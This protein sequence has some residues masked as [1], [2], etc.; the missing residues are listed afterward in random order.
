MIA[1]N[2]RFL[3]KIHLEV[4]RGHQRSE[5]GKKAQIFYLPKKK[6]RS[7][8]SQAKS[9]KDICYRCRTGFTGFQEINMFLTLTL[10]FLV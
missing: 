6:I 2:D 7:V 5:F 1:F 8:L 3:Y 4:T 10:F 9:D